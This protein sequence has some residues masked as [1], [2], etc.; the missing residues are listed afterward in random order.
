MQRLQ[1]YVAVKD[2]T[3]SARFCV[4]LFAATPIVVKDD[5]AKLILL[6]RL[7]CQRLPA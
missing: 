4:T 5:Y 6:D 7:R 1:V 3:Q 2:I